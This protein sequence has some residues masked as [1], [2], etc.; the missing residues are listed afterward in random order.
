MC[1]R[2]H[3]TPENY[4]LEFNFDFSDK[5]RAEILLV[6]CKSLMSVIV[7]LFR[8]M[9]LISTFLLDMVPASRYY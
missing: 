9:F 6:A 4:V 3:D 8:G 5:I 2:G 1:A 7:R